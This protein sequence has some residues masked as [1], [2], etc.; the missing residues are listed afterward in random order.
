MPL[1]RSVYVPPPGSP[2]S[3]RTVSLRPVCDHPMRANTIFAPVKR[4]ISLTT[5]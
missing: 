2:D 3:Q 1:T 5:R 4:G